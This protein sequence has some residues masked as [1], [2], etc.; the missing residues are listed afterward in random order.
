MER[1][2]DLAKMKEIAASGPPPEHESYIKAS[3]LLADSFLKKTA[4]LDKVIETMERYP[5]GVREAA[6]WTF[7]EKI[8]SSMDLDNLDEILFAYRHYRPRQEEEPVK[9]LEEISRGYRDQLRKLRRAVKAGQYRQQLLHELVQEGISGTAL[10]GVNLK[11]SNWWKK[12][13]ESLAAD[14]SP[15]LAR[16]KEQLLR[17]LDKS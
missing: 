2:A 6:E 15:E 4:T 9:K 1:T 10:A 3:S 16:L 14:F 5:A 13:R 8:I 7:L 17:S 11:R 12:Q